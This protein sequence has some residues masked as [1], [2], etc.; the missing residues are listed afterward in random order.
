MLAPSSKNKLVVKE[1]NVREL[2]KKETFAFLFASFAVKEDVI[3]KRKCD[4]V[5]QL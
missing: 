3:M 2:T 5:L 1:I 4:I